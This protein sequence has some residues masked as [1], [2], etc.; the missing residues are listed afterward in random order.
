[1]P[2]TSGAP[3]YGIGRGGES[4]IR[5]VLVSPELK[6]TMRCH[7]LERSREFLRDHPRVPLVDEWSEAHGNGC[8]YAVGAGLLELNQLANATVSTDASSAPVK[9]FDVQF[10]VSDLDQWIER[11][12]DRWDHPGPK[13]QP[14]G[15]R[16]LRLRDPDGVLVTIYQKMS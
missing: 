11:I 7:D 13:T 15:E 2:V 14:W 1:M 4:L 8:I 5:L 10:D 9:R 3:T 6:I 12:G 16:T